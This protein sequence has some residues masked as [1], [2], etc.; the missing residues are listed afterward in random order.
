[1]KDLAKAV[2][3]IEQNLIKTF[4]DAAN[5]ASG[6]NP[7]MADFDA[8]WKN[9]EQACRDAGSTSTDAAREEVKQH[10]T[11][12]M[13]RDGMSKDEAE[14]WFEQKWTEV[15][16][17]AD[18]VIEAAPKVVAAAKYGWLKVVGAIAA[19]FGGMVIVGR[20]SGPDRQTQAMIDY[21]HRQAIYKAQVQAIQRITLQQVEFNAFIRAIGEPLKFEPPGPAPE[22]MPARVEVTT[23]AGTVTYNTTYGRVYD[24]APAAVQSAM[25]RERDD[26]RSSGSDDHQSSSHHKTFTVSTDFAS[27]TISY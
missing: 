17:L 4:Q 19:L 7:T 2:K 21:M 16:D 8:V 13:Q 5:V 1:V 22:A 26:D 3:D 11:K 12:Q 27:A 14:K 10:I 24:E 20:L 15:K 18:R 9:F 6:S 25:R 23:N